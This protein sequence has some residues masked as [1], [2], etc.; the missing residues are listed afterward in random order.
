MAKDFFRENNV[1]WWKTVA[2]SPDLNP[3]ENLWH[4]FKEYTQREIK[5]KRK[6][7]LVDGIKQ[8]LKTVTVQKSTKYI[9]RLRKVIP[10]VIEV[11]GE[12]TGY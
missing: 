8:F 7:E 12:P 3:I 6:K 11:G 4:E 1:N 9:R 5:A 2:K 10:K